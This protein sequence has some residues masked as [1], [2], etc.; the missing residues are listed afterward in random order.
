MFP[1]S[2]IERSILVPVGHPLA[3]LKKLTLEK[4][5]QFS[6]ISLDASLAGGSGIKQVFEN[7]DLKPNFVLSATDTD[8]IKTYVKIGHGIAIIPTIA[9][10]KNRDRD[11]LIL[12]ASGLFPTIPIFIQIRRGKYLR[13]FMEDFITM[14]CPNWNGEHLNGVLY[15]QK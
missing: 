3:K 12:D 14:V 2:T 1:Y 4:I 5:A 6:I 10:D 9:Y 11:L 15:N 13:H 8:V 7:S